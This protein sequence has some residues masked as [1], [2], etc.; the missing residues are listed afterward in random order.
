MGLLQ[1]LPPSSQITETNQSG[2]CRKR[3]APTGTGSA[4]S[5]MPSKACKERDPKLFIENCS[6]MG[7]SELVKHGHYNVVHINQGVMHPGHSTYKRG[8]IGGL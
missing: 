6:G 5:V 1:Y 7:K 2:G 8:I 3:K 4:E